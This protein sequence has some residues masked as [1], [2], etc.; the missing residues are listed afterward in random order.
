M[1]SDRLYVVALGIAVIVIAALLNDVVNA[2]TI[3]YDILVGGLLVP[4]LGGFLWK[5]ATGVGALCSMA[6]GTVVTLGTMVVFGVAANEPIYYGLAASLIGYVVGSLLT[7]RTPAN[8]LQVWDDRLAGGDAAEVE[9]VDKAVAALN[10]RATQAAMSALADQTRW[11]DATDQAALVASGEVSPSELLEAAIERIERIDP[12]LNAVVIRWFDH[13]RKTAASADLPNGPFR[14]VPFLIKDLFA[15]VR[16]A[17]DQ[18][19]QRRVQG[20]ARHRRRRHDTRQPPPCGRAG[21]RRPHEQPRARQRADH[22]ARRVGRDPQPVGHDA[23]ARWIERRC[24]RR[25]RVGDGAVRPRQ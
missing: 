6:A 3:A 5:R 4:I 23:H 17:A 8:V 15:D 19:R 11:M 25:G 9:A 10:I 14:G 18:Q 13:A 1:H 7:P 20:G 2:L 16:G 24:G 21:D 22:R 12:A